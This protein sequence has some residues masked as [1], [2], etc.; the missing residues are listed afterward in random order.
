MLDIQANTVYIH[1][2]IL[3]D[4][5]MFDFTGHFD[6]RNTYINITKYVV[7]VTEINFY[8]SIYAR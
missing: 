1:Y 8:L 2:D 6:P 3:M 4:E 5:N 7:L